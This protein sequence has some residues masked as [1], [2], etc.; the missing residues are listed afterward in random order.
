VVSYSGIRQERETDFMYVSVHPVYFA[1]TRVHSQLHPRNPR[2]IAQIGPSTYL[3]ECVCKDDGANRRGIPDIPVRF[4][5]SDHEDWDAFAV[6]FWR[7][8]ENEKQRL[9]YN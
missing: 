9:G 2:I 5:F 8:L 7:F 1:L 4:A 6:R 3:A